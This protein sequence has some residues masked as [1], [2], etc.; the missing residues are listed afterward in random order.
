MG[1]GHGITGSQLS[2]PGHSTHD[3]H[4]LVSDF[5]RMTDIGIFHSLF[6]TSNLAPHISFGRSWS[7]QTYY[8][9]PHWRGPKFCVLKIL[10]SKLF[11]IKILQTLFAK[12]APSKTFGGVGEAGVPPLSRLLSQTGTAPRRFIS[13][14]NPQREPFGTVSDAAC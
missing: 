4:S 2:K 6:V 12:P 3:P 11:D 5:E 10:T 9:E 1:A 7:R 8:G 13:R 14:R